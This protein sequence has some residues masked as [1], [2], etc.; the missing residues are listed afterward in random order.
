MRHWPYAHDRMLTLTQDHQ[1]DR[2]GSILGAFLAALAGLD[3]P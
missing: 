3:F 2:A 1:N